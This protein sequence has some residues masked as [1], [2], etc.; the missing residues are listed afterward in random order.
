M[1]DTDAVKAFNE[2][3]A[4]LI[5]NADPADVV[6][7]LKDENSILRAHQNNN[8]NREVSEKQ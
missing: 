4:E 8:N 7:I 3:V 6:G 2:K 1:A 5:K